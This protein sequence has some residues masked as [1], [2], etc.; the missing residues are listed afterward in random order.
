M[1]VEM[2]FPA[3]IPR[4]ILAVVLLFIL[5][6]V[7]GGGVGADSDNIDE[8]FERLR[9][10]EPSEVNAIERLILL[11]WSDPGSPDLRAVFRQGQIALAQ[12]D[13]LE[14]VRQFSKLIDR[15][16]DF[17]EGWNARATTYFLMNQFNHSIADIGMTL[18]LNPRHFGAMNGLAMILE[19]V[20]DHEG[21]LAVNRELLSIH[22]TRRGVE[23]AIK[24]LEAKITDPEV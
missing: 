12:G 22:P 19:R 18:Q 9:T 8:L 7:S 2:L 4:K 5:L 15:A 6:V 17:A 10:A 1:A 24:R 11:A 20:E 3:K 16:P 14:S 23:Q 13:F 21:A